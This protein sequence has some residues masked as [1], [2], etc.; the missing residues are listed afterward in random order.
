M[1]YAV[2]TTDAGQRIYQN[3]SFSLLKDG[4]TISATLMQDFSVRALY[5]LAVKTKAVVKAYYRKEH[6]YAYFDGQSQGG[7]QV[8][9]M[10]QDYTDLYDGYLAAAPGINQET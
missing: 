8:L 5:E 7:R 1:G 6:K 9:K 4:S 10:A 3:G 2:G